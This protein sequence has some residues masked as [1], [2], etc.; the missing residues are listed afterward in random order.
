MILHHVNYTVSYNLY[1]IDYTSYSRCQFELE[2]NTVAVLTDIFMTKISCLV[3][4]RSVICRNYING[5]T[6]LM[7]ENHSLRNNINI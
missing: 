7:E 3:K 2:I 6:I 5:C 1:C 4:W